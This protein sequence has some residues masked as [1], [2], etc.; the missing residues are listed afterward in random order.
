MLPLGEQSEIECYNGSPLQIPSA[1]E[2]FVAD[3][4]LT[5]T[6][7]TLEEDNTEDD[8]NDSYYYFIE[9]DGEIEDEGD[10]HD[11]SDG[12]P[13]PPGCLPEDLPSPLPA[14]PHHFKRDLPSELESDKPNNLHDVPLPA[15]ENY[16]KNEKSVCND[17]HIIPFPVLPP[18]P[19]PPVEKVSSAKD[20]KKI[21]KNEEEK[22]IP[23]PSKKI[24][25][26]DPQLIDLPLVEEKSSLDDNTRYEFFNFFNFF[27]LWNHFMGFYFLV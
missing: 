6:I 18:P 3:K 20:T 11:S 21:K 8:R 23:L 26:P 17:S 25:E 14:A 16:F 13:L 24:N 10:Q 7:Y 5:S 15:S 27:V 4:Y 19:P 22:S 9:E 2:G 12:P 1:E